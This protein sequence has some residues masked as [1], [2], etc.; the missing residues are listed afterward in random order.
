MTDFAENDV[1]NI[2]NNDVAQAPPVATVTVTS[3]PHLPPPTLPPPPVPTQPSSSSSQSPSS[4][5]LPPPIPPPLPEEPQ[6][7]TIPVPETTA[8]TPATTA[9]TPAT[10]VTAPV[11]P[12][13]VTSTAESGN[14]NKSLEEAITCPG[15]NQKFVSEAEGRD[16]SLLPKLLPSCFHTLCVKCIEDLQARDPKVTC[17]ICHNYN[18]RHVTKGI[19]LS[20]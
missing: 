12:A 10:V 18:G 13:T 17:P 9:E 16:S 4:L 2:D 11:S 14:S 7:E 8:E 19:R 20:S 3:A 1:S 15:C 6:E 5:P